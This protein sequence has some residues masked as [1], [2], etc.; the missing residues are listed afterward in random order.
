[1]RRNR[2]MP[3]PGQLALWTIY[4]VRGRAIGMPLRQVNEGQQRTGQPQ[5][6]P[7][8]GVVQ[9]CGGRSSKLATRV[10]FPSPALIVLAA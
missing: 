6:R 2:R 3:G 10:R 8:S 5:R 7:R 1:M 4:E 9:A